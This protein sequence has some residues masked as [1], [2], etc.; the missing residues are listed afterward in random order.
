MQFKKNSNL[1]IELDRVINPTG[2]LGDSEKNY[3]GASSPSQIH[4]EVIGGV[5]DN[6]TPESLLIW[7]ERWGKVQDL[8]LENPKLAPYLDWLLDH[9]AGYS[10]AEIGERHKVT[11]QI[12]FHK[13]TEANA[14]LKKKIQGHQF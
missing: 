11:R 12:A 8:I 3:A 4:G 14:Y 6:E 13:V 1:R 10:F 5:C 7:K 9:F 2:N